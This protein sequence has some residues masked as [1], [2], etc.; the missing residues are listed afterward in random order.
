M[1]SGVWLEALSEVQGR[2]PQGATRGALDRESGSFF[3]R[4]SRNDA[5]NRPFANLM[6]LWDLHLICSVPQAYRWTEVA[7]QVRKDI[8]VGWSGAGDWVCNRGALH[9]GCL[10]QPPTPALPGAG[11]FH[12]VSVFSWLSGSLLQ[13]TPSPPSFC[14]PM[15]DNIL[16]KQIF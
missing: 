9:G 4:T 10:P 16:L 5:Q 8:I 1:G 12:G 14:S 15:V 13:A 2:G 3:L 6:S 11:T 7:H